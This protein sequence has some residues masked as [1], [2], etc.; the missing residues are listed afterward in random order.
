MNDVLVSAGHRL[1]L[2]P[3]EFFYCS[4][5]RIS[6]GISKIRFTRRLVVSTHTLGEHERGAE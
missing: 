3:G 4:Q 6:S 5:R 1:I 2:I